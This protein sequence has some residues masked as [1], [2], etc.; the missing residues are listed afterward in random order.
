MCVGFHCPICVLFD[1]YNGTAFPSGE[2]R[3]FLGFLFGLAELV[4]VTGSIML[5]R[6]WPEFV[7]FLLLA[8]VAHS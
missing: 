1:C 4:G 3:S 6:R 8:N 5:Q 7:M 2:L